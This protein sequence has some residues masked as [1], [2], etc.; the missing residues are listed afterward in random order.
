LVWRVCVCVGGGGG[1]RV[2]KEGASVVAVSGAVEWEPLW[3]PRWFCCYC[4]PPRLMSR[5]CGQ[6]PL[7][8]HCRIS[9]LV[10]PC[11]CVPSTG[12]VLQRERRHV[13]L[14][15]LSLG[16][17]LHHPPGHCPPPLHPVHRVR[18]LSV[19]QGC[20]GHPARAPPPP[21]A[22]PHLRVHILRVLGGPSAAP[23]VCTHLLSPS[24][25][26]LGTWGLPGG[27]GACSRHLSTSHLSP[28][29]HFRD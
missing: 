4:V 27:G 26:G 18:L 9:C 17:L 21:E 25:L 5:L 2:G 11:C 22:V 23:A 24:F 19:V 28:H 12:L 16:G 13:L 14:G 3:K 15:A 6:V 7:H 20:A 8:V 10:F 29:L 1:L